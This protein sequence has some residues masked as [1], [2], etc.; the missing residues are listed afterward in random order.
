[1]R[2]YCVKERHITE[3]LNPRYEKAKNGRMMMK[4]TCASCGITKSQFVK[5]EGGAAP[6]KP[7]KGVK[8]PFKSLRK[9]QR[10]G[11]ILPPLDIH[12]AILK[13]APKKGFVLPGHNYTGPGNPLDSQLKYDPNTG[14]ILEIYQQPSGR[15][16]A[17]SMQH[18]VDYSVCSNK[19]KK[20]QLKC[21]NVA[22]RKMVKSLDSIPKSQRQWGHTVA[23]NAIAAKAKLGMGKSSS[24]PL[25]TL[26]R[27]KGVKKKS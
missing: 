6:L 23:R 4:S 17:V 15:T 3:S 10:G 21:K 24:Y 9:G 11:G 19:P 12:N 20:E 18:D 5:R 22:D 7:P 14:K 1:M 2:S 25:K 27:N 26:A 8:L 13:V 16:D